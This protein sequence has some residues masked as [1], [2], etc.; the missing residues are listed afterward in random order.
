MAPVFI[1]LVFGMVE[2]GRMV[3]I[4]QVLMNSADQGVRHAAMADSNFA[5]TRGVVREYLKESSPSGQSMQVDVPWHIPY[6]LP[7]DQLGRHV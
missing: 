5:S 4:Q 3:M 6:R 7:L 2:Y 1:L